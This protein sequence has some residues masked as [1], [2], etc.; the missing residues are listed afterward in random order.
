MLKISLSHFGAA[1]S[2]TL[3][4]PPDMTMALEILFYLHIFQQMKK[5]RRKNRQENQ[6]LVA[7]AKRF[8]MIY[9]YSEYTSN[10]K[11]EEMGSATKR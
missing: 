1:G 9:T 8:P 3:P 6:I 5:E 4:G 10:I 7:L 11:C 2:K